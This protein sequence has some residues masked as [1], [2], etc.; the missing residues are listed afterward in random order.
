[1]LWDIS[2]TDNNW[3]GFLL[4]FF[5]FYE[6]L[7]RLVQIL[8]NLTFWHF[9]TWIFCIWL[10]FFFKLIWLFR[11]YYFGAFVNLTCLFW[12]VLTSLF[13]LD[14]FAFLTWLSTWVVFFDLTWL[15]CIWLD[16]IFGPDLTFVNLLSWIFDLT[17][18]FD[19]TCF[20]AFFDDLFDL[21]TFHPPEGRSRD[22]AGGD[23]PSRQTGSRPL[24]KPTKE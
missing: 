21:T 10:D 12:S 3:F 16:L 15:F 7:T 13:D 14:F 18:L 5:G 8:S 4:T 24:P 11:H 23:D 9:L 22:A 6:F 20:F 1:M 17:W 19:L 2:M